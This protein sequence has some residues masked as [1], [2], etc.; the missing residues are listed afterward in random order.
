MVAFVDY[1]QADTSRGEYVLL[2]KDDFYFQFNRAK[3]FNV[4]TSRS[5]NKVVLVTPPDEE[6]FPIYSR[7]E[8]AL[9]GRETYPLNSITTLEVCSLVFNDGGMDYADIRIY[10]TAEESPCPA[11]PV[12]ENDQCP[13][14][15][16]VPVGT[17]IAGNTTYA[18]PDEDDIDGDLCSDSDDDESP[19]VWFTIEGTGRPM[20]VDTLNPGTT[21]DTKIAVFSGSCGSLTCVSSNDDV[22]SSIPQSSLTWSS[23]ALEEYKVLV[24]GPALLSGYFVLSVNEVPTEEP[25]QSP[26]VS[27]APTLAPSFSPTAIPTP[28]P[29]PVPTPAPTLM[30]TN[31]PSRTPNYARVGPMSDASKLGRYTNRGNARK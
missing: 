11:R 4:G 20:T 12:P 23:Q 24:Y 2:R 22:S 13:D 10:P 18:T 17:T 14:A 29:T 26:S 27:E 15:L 1:E 6:Q 5:R 7:H 19:G 8:A 21:Y 30:P 28:S 16:S 9:A 3:S 31:T 25:S